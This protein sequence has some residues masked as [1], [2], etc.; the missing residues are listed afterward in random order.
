MH[1]Q[2]T[3]VLSNG[4]QEN[5]DNR[6][7]IVGMFKQKVTEAE[8]KKL[9]RQQ[10]RGDKLDATKGRTNSALKNKK[11]RKGKVVKARNERAIIA[12]NKTKQKQQN[13]VWP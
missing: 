6:K 11:S 9:E 1:T 7:E 13:D 3:Q 5:T 10:K 4:I 12:E 8:N 2:K